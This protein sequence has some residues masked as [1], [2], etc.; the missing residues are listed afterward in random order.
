MFSGHSHLAKS[1]TNSWMQPQGTITGQLPVSNCTESRQWERNRSK[2]RRQ[3]PTARIGETMAKKWDLGS[4]SHVL[5]VLGHSF[6]ISGC[7]QFP[8]FFSPPFFPH[9]RFPAMFPSY[10]AA[11][12]RSERVNDGNIFVAN[13]TVSEEDMRSS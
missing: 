11:D 3:L 12:S 8:S 9:F 5:R 1:D 10:Q 6:P 7:G 4:L 2:K 13:G